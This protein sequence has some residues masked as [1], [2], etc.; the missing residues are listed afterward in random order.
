MID[1]PTMEPDESGVTIIFRLLA[2]LVSIVVNLVSS[3]SK[4]IKSSSKDQITLSNLPVDI[5]RTI[6]RME[7][8]TMENLRPISKSWNHHIRELLYD[9][10]D[11]LILHEVIMVRSRLT[12]EIKANV[13]VRQE[14]APRI[15]KILPDWKQIGPYTECKENYVCFEQEILHFDGNAL[16]E[17][18]LSSRKDATFWGNKISVA[19]NFD[20]GST[21]NSAIDQ[22]SAMFYPCRL[23]VQD[24]TTRFLKINPLRVHSALLDTTEFRHTTYSEMAEADPSKCGICW[25]DIT[26]KRTVALQC[27]HS[28]HRTCFVNLCEST[29]LSCPICPP[30]KFSSRFARDERN[31]GLPLIICYGPTGQLSP[32]RWRAIGLENYS[33]FTSSSD[34]HLEIIAEWLLRTS[35]DLKL[36][37]KA[38]KPAEYIR[39]IID[40]RQKLLDRYQAFVRLQEEVADIQWE[41]AGVEDATATEAVAEDDCDSK[42]ELCGVCFEGIRRKRSATLE[43]C[44]HMF[45]RTCITRWLEQQQEDFIS[46]REKPVDDPFVFVYKYIYSV[47]AGRSKE[48]VDD[49]KEEMEKYKKR[50]IALARFKFSIVGKKV[51]EHAANI[52]PNENSNEQEREKSNEETAHANRHARLAYDN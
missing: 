22:Y 35:E 17:P 19:E 51:N 33:E 8:E 1:S 23:N 49:I 16:P 2:L 37:R 31:K 44:K 13:N 27:G 20:S 11:P 50:W 3:I 40:E 48:Y 4:R 45:H 5:I 46:G 47:R 36:A 24:R 25:Q 28:L 34:Y 41:P 39:D 26:I 7:G 15:A 21:K 32:F 9:R 18:D 14:F 12:G 30:R 10:N 43:P 29:R 38:G 42:E 52:P 6:V